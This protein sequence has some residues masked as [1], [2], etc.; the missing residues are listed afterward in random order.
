MLH[1]SVPIASCVHC[2]YLRWSD[3]SMVQVS[4]FV[5]CR[6]VAFICL[7]ATRSDFTQKFERSPPT[8][9][10]DVRCWFRTFFSI[11]TRQAL[12]EAPAPP[13][14]AWNLNG[15]DVYFCTDKVN[16]I[17]NEACVILT[18]RTATERARI[19]RELGGSSYKTVLFFNSLSSSSWPTVI[20]DEHFK[21]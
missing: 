12:T 5:H 3:L 20:H 1:S 18:A 19:M 14:Q 21:C 15:V 10:V 17:R 13:A 2:L 9:R 4:G 16:R 11:E 8:L 7:F 6:F